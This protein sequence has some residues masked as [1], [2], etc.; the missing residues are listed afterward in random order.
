MTGRSEPRS[1]PPA[2]R[3]IAGAFRLFGW[4]S[5]WIQLVLGVVAAGILLL[6][7]I[8]PAPNTGANSPG[9]GA[10]L[11]LA[12]G[13]IL[14]LFAG[15]LWAFRYSRL[16]RQLRFGDSN[17]RPKPKDV[18][19]A[20]QIG[21]LIS[22]LGML[23]TLLGAEIIVGSLFVK[24]LSQLGAGIALDRTQYIQP[25]DI[26]IVQASTH[27]AVAHFAAIAIALYLLR[28]VNR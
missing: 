6:L 19:Q 20:I 14:A 11:F 16:A 17:S 1:L 24:S 26:F 5:F 22:L 4:I 2:V 28:L 8:S 13:G 9:T 7:T 3:R 12:T 25:L 21:L 18:L 27:T 10:G 23:L 15:A